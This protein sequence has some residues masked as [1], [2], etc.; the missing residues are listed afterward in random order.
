[1][2]A[3]QGFPNRHADVAARIEEWNGRAL[4]YAAPHTPRQFGESCDRGKVD[5][6]LFQVSSPLAKVMCFCECLSDYIPP[7]AT[8]MG[9]KSFCPY[10]FNK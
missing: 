6:G 7:L 3:F 9:T 2:A 4:D 10:P 8:P 1:M 5:G